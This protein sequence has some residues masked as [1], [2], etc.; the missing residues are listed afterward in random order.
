MNNKKPWIIV[1]V[2]AGLMAAS[3][4]LNLNTSGVFYSPVSNDLNILRGTFALHMTLF[5]LMQGICSFVIPTILK[6]IKFKS[7][8]IIS[9]IICALSTLAM[10]LV[11]TIPLFYV[12]GII[13]GI[14]SAMF[15]TVTLS[16]IINNWFK[17]SHGLALSIVF[18][19]SGLGGAVGS[20]I[21]SNVITAGGWR[22]GY[23]VNAL[24]IAILCLPAILYPFSL[25]P[26]KEGLL[27]YGLSE[28]PHPT[29]IIEEDEEKSKFNFINLS[30]FALI[31]L[32]ILVSF[33]SSIAQH[34]PGYAETINLAN[35]GS[36]MVSAGMIG[37]ITFKVIIGILSDKIGAVKASIIMMCLT[38]AGLVTVLLGQ[39]TL[40]LVVGAFIFGSCYSVGA[41]AASLLVVEFF[42]LKYY[43]TVYPVVNFINNAGAAVSLSIIGFIYD[44]FNSYKIAII[45]CIVMLIISI[46]SLILAEVHRQRSFEL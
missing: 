15:S 26:E 19:A 31:I 27:P 39:N 17:K 13:R 46:A 4:G 11:S 18:S 22:M 9:V 6:K 20:I 3:V 35:A 14:S 42:G 12:L 37:N 10:G 8:I 28:E 23:F 34:F 43:D 44:L 7:L 5:T 25:S 41:V 24:L 21:L 38:I 40:M 33:T 2:C 32:G 29:M 30:L 16:T 1:A 45:L 36:L